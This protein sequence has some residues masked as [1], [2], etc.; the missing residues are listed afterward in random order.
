MMP[1]AAATSYIAGAPVSS[2]GTSLE[3]TSPATGMVFGSVLLSDRATVAAAVTAA[4]DA[5]PAWAATPST[6]RARL[7]LK[8]AQLI[9]RERDAL[10]ALITLDN[11]KT[12][13]DARGE[14]ARSIDH[15]EAAA[16]APALLAGDAV[17]DILP[18][19]DAMMLREPLGVCAVVS[20]F[21]FPIMTGLIYW[22]WALACGNTVV[23]KPSEQTPYAMARIAELATEAGF[24]A[25]V[26]NVVQGG[27]E[28]VEALCDLD[29][30]RSISLVGSSATALAVYARATANGKRVHTAGGA[31]NPIVVLP[32][33]PIDLAADG[34]IASAY[35]MAG[36]RCLSGSILVTVGGVHDSLV[37]AIAQRAAKLVTAAGDAEGTDVPPLISR[38]AVDSLASTIGDAVAEG[39]TAVLDGRNRIE[40]DGGYFH[41]PSLLDGVSAESSLLTRESFGPIV[42][43]VDVSDLDAALAVVNGSPF[44]NAASLYTTSG[45]SARRFMAEA[46]VGNIGINV[47]V[48]APTAQV[49]FGGKRRSFLGTVH[50]QGRHAVEFFTDIK[51]VSTR[52]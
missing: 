12:L 39:A 22:S 25:G 37:E 43:V 36:Q 13:T 35:T 5:F 21:N 44:G 42:S 11:G 31:R 6:S 24:P 4:N 27:R 46:S 17:L 34:V 1:D 47:G 48:A 40:T 20:P 32:D 51:S 30:V 26:M 28:A 23:I 2:S 9:N 18:G 50:S 29:D 16:T 38:Q 52:W 3:V 15:L 14:L 41:G 19:L 45:A 10:A 7:L 49:G 8:L 33:S